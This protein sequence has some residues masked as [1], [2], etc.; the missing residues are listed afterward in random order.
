MEGR[1]RPKLDV[2]PEGWKVLGWAGMTFGAV[3][4]VGLIAVVALK[5]SDAL[6]SIALVLAIAAFIV[7][8]IVSALQNAASRAAEAAS[9][10]LNFE[11]NKA[12]EQIKANAAANQEILARQF[13]TLL[14]ALVKGRDAGL[15]QK[16][17]TN[18]GSSSQPE[19]PTDFRSLGRRVSLGPSQSDMRILEM[20]RSFPDDEEARQLLKH[21]DRLSPAAAAL[22][23]RY[24]ED[25]LQSREAGAEPGLAASEAPVVSKARA[26]LLDESLLESRGD[27]Y[28]SLTD[29]GRQVARL[30][31]ATGDPPP[32]VAEAF[33]L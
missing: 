16:S 27:E 32:S 31:R 22:L 18:G 7:Q 11:T 25:E 26:T 8:I 13:D 10:G 15:G 21:F 2:S 14:D 23:D 1:S 30:L 28:F 12:L 3:C 17:E 4:L 19:A 20:L 5:H 24:A 9:R 6:A 33:G 29:Q